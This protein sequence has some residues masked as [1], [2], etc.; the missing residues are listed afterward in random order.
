MGEKKKGT[1]SVYVRPNCTHN[2]YDSL[3][4]LGLRLAEKRKENVVTHW[5]TLAN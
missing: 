1:S 5:N 2:G 4:E 3:D